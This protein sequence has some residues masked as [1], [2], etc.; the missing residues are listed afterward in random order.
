LCLTGHR[1]KLLNLNKHQDFRSLEADTPSK[2]FFA[3]CSIIMVK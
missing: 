1:L 3:C 2:N